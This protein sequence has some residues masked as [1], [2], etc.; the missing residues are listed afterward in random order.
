MYLVTIEQEGGLKTVHKVGSV[1]SALT[2]IQQHATGLI[3]ATIE[4][5]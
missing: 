4:K 3:S 5:L 2:F 1:E